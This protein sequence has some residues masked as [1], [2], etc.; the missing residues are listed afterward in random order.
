MWE[1]H[2]VLGFNS[3]SGKKYLNKKGAADKAAP[4]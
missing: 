4:R 2:S 1:A 3:D